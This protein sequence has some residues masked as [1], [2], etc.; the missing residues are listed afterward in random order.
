MRVLLS[1]SLLF[2]S[3]STL[4]GQTPTAESFGQTAAGE[5]VEIYTLRSEQGLVAK[6]MTRG[7]T[8]VNLLVPDRD[9]K[10]ADVIFGFDNVAG[11]ESD[12][13]SYFGCTTGR[14]C[15]RIAKG[16]FTLEGK[17]Y[18]LAINNEPNHLHGG[19]SRSLDK[20]IW[21]ARP[22]TNERG[23]GVEFSYTSPDGEEG[24]PGNLN[25]KVQYFVAKARNNLTVRY[26]A[27]TDKATPVN[28]TNHAYF[29]LAGQG[30]GTILEH[31][32]KLN[33]DRYTPTDD[34][35]IPTGDIKSV[36]GTALDFRKP[37]K[38]GKRI[39]EVTATAALGYD[40][41]FV[42]NPKTDDR[43][44]NQAAVLTEPSSGRRLQIS[45]TEPGIQFYS[46]NFL[47]GAVGKGGKSYIHRGALCLETQHY[48]DSINH[49][50]F[51]NTVLKPGEKF[52]SQTLYSF[53]TN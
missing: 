30:N 53:G 45:T 17:E 10:V 25:V 6:V 13:N 11:Y 19:Q 8:L 12:R 48:P 28:L 50:E 36:E 46:G 20:V 31:T 7:A 24:Y 21:K 22:Y 23:Q 32:L 38:I 34:T 51:P 1:I 47:T 4:I 2:A 9:G 35:L 33:A 27:T 39:K 49:P 44:L 3:G 16:K 41:N 15:N 37:T 42:L 40:H 18:S 29:N 52:N 14:V 5:P 26:I 43:P